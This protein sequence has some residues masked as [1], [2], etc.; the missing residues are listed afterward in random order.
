M[1][2]GIFLP[3]CKFKPVD[4]DRFKTIIKECYYGKKSKRRRKLLCS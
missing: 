2:Q 4:F 1:Q 3:C